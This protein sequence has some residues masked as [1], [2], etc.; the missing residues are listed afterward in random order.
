MARHPILERHN[1]IAGFVL[2]VVGVVYAVLL[3]F[4]AIG[5]W[6]RFE[7]ADQRTYDEAVRLTE[8]YRKA[9]LF[10]QGHL[11]RKELTR[12]VGLIVDDEWNDMQQGMEDRKTDALVELVA[13]QVRHMPGSRLPY[14]DGFAGRE[15]LHVSRTPTAGRSCSI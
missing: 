13:S 3:A 11:L 12:Y 15:S 10:P 7:A 4:L 5:V 8:V 2:A 6:E 9:D 1:E 14:L